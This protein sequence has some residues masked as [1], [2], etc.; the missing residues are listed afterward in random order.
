MLSASHS[1]D[2]LASKGERPAIAAPY[3]LP[4][5]TG[6]E[7]FL[8]L[9]ASLAQRPRRPTRNGGSQSLASRHSPSSWLG[10]LVFLLRNSSHRRRQCARGRP[11]HRVR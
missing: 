5:E 10:G 3:N 9:I 11:S 7:V 1:K 4:G 8:V 6:M 2:A